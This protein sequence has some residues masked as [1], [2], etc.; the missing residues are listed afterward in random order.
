MRSIERDYKYLLL[1]LIPHHRLSV[2]RRKHIE[3]AIESGDPGEIRQV[4]ILALE[5]LCRTRFYQRTETRVDNGNVLLTYA[6]SQ[7]VFQI[8]VQVPSGL[9]NTMGIETGEIETGEAADEPLP[10]PGVAAP[11]VETTIEILPDVIRSLSIN[12]EH[13]STLERL[14]SVMTLLPSGLRFSGGRLILVDERI[15]GR[16]SEGDMVGSDT[17]KALLNQVIY[18]RCRQ[19]RQIETLEGEA[20]RALGIADPMV[21]RLRSNQLSQ[22]VVA[23]APIFAH[24]EFWGILEMWLP[25]AAVDS[26]L[27]KRI[28]VIV[29]L[30]EQVIE[31]A[32]RLENLTSID[33]LTQVYNRHF[34]D[35]QVRVEIER[36][37]RSG[38]KLSILILDIDDFKAINDTL[39]HRKGD[40]ALFV[41]ADLIK[42]NLRKIDLPFRYGGEEFVILLPG[43]SETEAIHT[44]ERLRLVVS[45]YDEFLAAD[46]S[47]RTIQVSIGAAVFPDHA[48]TEEELFSKADT[49]LYQ[50]K[51]GGK[52]RV[53]F[54]KE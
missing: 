29:G 37:T 18:Q 9:W 36:A 34:Y 14:E 22:Y 8:R 17:E 42:K 30:I 43:T 44:A 23:V 12:G 28:Q 15:G 25:K 40:E 1:N 20:A 33:K 46:G 51:R 21:S 38:T 32:I 52:N 19:T 53:E 4:S 5:D 26:L 50:A 41:V 3:R 11:A 13:E 47:R 10:E 54:F 6:R 45:E 31:N 7:G 49:A 48:R 35:S 16:Q 27:G 24:G 39:G 2:E